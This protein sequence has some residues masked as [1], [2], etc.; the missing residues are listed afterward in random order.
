VFGRRLACPADA[1][2]P[3]VGTA[4]CGAS[5]PRAHACTTPGFESLE[6]IRRIPFRGIG[7]HKFQAVV[8]NALAQLT[9]GIRF[10]SW[11]D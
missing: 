1:H 6:I 8:A 5:L 11:F 3:V 9:R 10:V 2:R 7:G 4:R